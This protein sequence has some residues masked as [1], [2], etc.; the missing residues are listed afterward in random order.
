MRVRFREGRAVEGV[1]A[2][3]KP[4]KLVRAAFSLV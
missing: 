2:Q 4:A 3:N 1:E